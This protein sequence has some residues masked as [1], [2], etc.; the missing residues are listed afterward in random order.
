MAVSLCVLAGA[1]GCAGVPDADHALLTVEQQ[2][3]NVEAFDYVWTT[4]RD[5]HF[6]PQLNGV[7]W[8]AVREEL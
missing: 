6:D 5:K 4:I 2:A 7:D 8:Q 1:V 3:L